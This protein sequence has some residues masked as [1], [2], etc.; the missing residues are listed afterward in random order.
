MDELS[1][2]HISAR[3]SNSEALITHGNRMFDGQGPE[4]SAPAT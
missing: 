4:K 2:N 3:M 1:W